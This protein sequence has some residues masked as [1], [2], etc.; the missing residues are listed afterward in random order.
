MSAQPQP[1]IDPFLADRLA[2]EKQLLGALMHYES[3]YYRRAAAF[4]EQQHFVEP[5]H[6]IVFGLIGKA[7]EAGLDGFAKA[8]HVRGALHG[9]PGLTAGQIT[10]N[11]MVAAYIAAACPAV[12]IETCA[13]QVVRD[14][15]L[16][17]LKAA[18]A[19]GDGEG[20]AVIG[21][22]IVQLDAAMSRR[23]E[24]VAMVGDVAESVIDG[25]NA[26]YQ[27]G[28]VP[29]IYADCGSAELSR[30]MGG[31]KRKR[32]YFIA[33]RPGMGKTTLAVSLLRR[34]AQ[35]GHGVLL[36]SQE[37]T[38]EEVVEMMLC[39]AVWTRDERIEYRQIAAS[40]V[41]DDDF[42]ARFARI[43]CMRPTLAKS[44]L[45]I[46]DKPSMTMGQIRALAAEYAL[47]LKAKG[48]RLDVI[49]IDH[50]GLC[51]AT[52][53]Y[54]GNRT[55][56]T[57]E[58]AIDL[59]ALA[60]ELDCAVVA[61]VQLNRG[62]EARDDKR[63]QLS[64]LRQ[65]GAIEENAD[66]VMMVYRHAYYL[67]RKKF[68]DMALQEAHKLEIAKKANEIEVVFGKQRQGP[69]PIV[70]MFCDMGCGVVRDREWRHG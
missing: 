26:A 41:L 15:L 33:G 30:V 65:S 34:T 47:K 39:D 63:P 54:A 5:Y 64:D 20:A 17:G 12:T 25:L 70:T 38:K 10:A 2:N 40:E 13:R 3:A 35:K 6:G 48:Q 46:C 28:S 60:K 21:T 55:A 58:V 42:P 67:E 7:V 11:Q 32:L 29:E 37:M 22:K 23:G 61:L 8:Q 45:M 51:R 53:R 43:N 18:A 57:E 69:V 50:M 59:K 24:Q 19:N 68:D 9:H 31:W 1:S 49:A 16:E 62:V 66:V 27:A 4:L 56:E 44:P 52:D 14:Y 36:F